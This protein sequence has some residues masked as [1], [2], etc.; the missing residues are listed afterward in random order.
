MT[1]KYAPRVPV[2]PERYGATR[3][4]PLRL[5]VIH[6]SEG[7]ESETA[8][9]AL[10]AAFARPGD[11]WVDED[12]HS[13]GKY[14]ASY[15]Y[16]F[17]TDDVIPV[18]PENVVAYAAGGAN[19]DGVHACFPGKASQT[20]EQWLD[21]VSSAMIDR[22]A[23]WLLDRS[24]ALHIP[25]VWLTVADVRA[26]LWGV[27]DHATISLAYKKST[28]TDP[29][30]AFPRDVLMQR[31]HKVAA[32]LPPVQPATPWK[33]DDMGMRLIQPNDK[34]A[35]LF[36]VDGLDAS[37]AVAGETIEGLIDAGLLPPRR[38]NQTT[39]QWEWPIQPVARPTLKAL[40]L[41]GK[42]PS[43]V[44]VNPDVFP[45]RTVTGDFASAKEA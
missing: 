24:L 33:D 3:T 23:E 11:R 17:D 30:A 42:L 28:H 37:S 13:R 18:V 29:G 1:V 43:Y 32:P 14:G 6:D 38:Q 2:H 41:R 10:A 16:V 26:G 15:H 7:A 40:H 9:E 39:K 45:T 35:A 5:L 8:A 36:L 22:A 19:N 34:D 20:R 21:P 4:N 44:G 27:T 25:L 12:D 31:A